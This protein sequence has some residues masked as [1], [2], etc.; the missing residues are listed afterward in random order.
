MSDTLYARVQAAAEDT[1]YRLRRTGRGFDMTVDVPGLGRNTTQ[2]HTYRVELHPRDKTFTMTDIV[3]THER[4]AFGTS[5]R[6]VKR[7]RVRY[8]TWS[9]SLDGSERTSFS[10]ADGRRLIRGAAQELGWR[11]LR[12]PTGKAALVFGAI[13]GLTALGTLIALAVVFWP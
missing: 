8:R 5:T 9:R 10:S 6:T 11:E 12:P 3:R 13:G 1:S 7:G 2:V 4:G